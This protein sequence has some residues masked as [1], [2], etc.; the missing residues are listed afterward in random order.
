MDNQTTVA[1]LKRL[2]LSKTQRIL[3]GS[4]CMKKGDVKKLKEIVNDNPEIVNARGGIQKS[5]LLH[6]CA[7]NNF[8]RLVKFLLE[9]GAEQKLDIHG[10][11]PLHYACITGATD[12]VQSL[13]GSKVS[14]EARNFEGEKPANLAARC[15]NMEVLLYL[16][17]QGA[18]GEEGYHNNTVLHSAAEKGHLHIIQKLV[19]KG[20]FDINE[21]NDLGETP[22]HIAAGYA[23]GGL[24]TIKFLLNSGADISKITKSGRGAA[25]YAADTGSLE[26]MKFL[27][28]NGSPISTVSHI[29]NQMIKTNESSLLKLVAL[30]GCTRKGTFLLD[31]VMAAKN[32]YDRCNNLSDMCGGTR[33]GIYIDEFSLNEFESEL[34]VMSQE[35]AEDPDNPNS[36][37]QT[38]LRNNP[39]ALV[40]LFDRCLIN[41]DGQKKV[42]N[43]NVVF[44]FFLFKCSG[45]TKNELDL[46]EII[47][48]SGKRKLLEHPLFEIFLQMKWE[49]SKGFFSIFFMIFLAHF[50]GLLGFSL[51]KFS[52]DEE[53]QTYSPYFRCG[54]FV[55]TTFILIQE[56]CISI[57][58]LISVYMNWR[59]KCSKSNSSR[60]RR[61]TEF[62]N[63]IFASLWYVDNILSKSKSIFSALSGVCVLITEERN[64]TV[65]SLVWTSHIFMAAVTRIP[66]IGKNVFLTT[67]VTFT[68]L[69]FLLSYLAEI[70]AFVVAFHILLPDSEAF[71]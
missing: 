11:Y 69:E 45:S 68:I 52:K 6:R 49:Q 15:G 20:G 71:R 22:L 38:F 65:I 10:N 7:K 17:E 31:K 70:L 40:S 62:S 16:L 19:E 53:L 27:I 18:T 26:A 5:T 34:V 24:D 25:H 63:V 64:I 50:L 35:L 2:T 9:K 59:S 21:E 4:E 44:D 3:N 46:I 12:I 33:H 14:I 28:E 32:K 41:D 58:L 29:K 54:L 61:L 42:E 1:F 39:E 60:N 55:T 48:A 51:T 8:P 36:I 23:R 47:Y 13:L 37:F 57:Y 30:S 56:I 43:A 67:Q 66:R